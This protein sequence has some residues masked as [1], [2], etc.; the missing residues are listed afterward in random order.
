MTRPPPFRASL[1]P[2]PSTPCPDIATFDVE[3]D[4]VDAAAFALRYRLTGAIDRIRLPDPAEPVR[5]DGLWRHTCL[6][7]FVGAP[8]GTGYVEYNFA[9]SGAWAAYA[10]DG[11]REGMRPHE[12]MPPAIV[13]T[14]SV[15]TLVVAVSGALPFQLSTDRRLAL[16]IT[17]VIESRDGSL[18]YWALA[19]PA[20]RPDFH[21]R[22][23]HVLRLGRSGITHPSETS[24]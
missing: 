20:D 24:A 3:V 23:G 15:T 13:A 22:D 12:T 7:L 6:E 14:P 9:P 5:T 19:H 17:A 10:F 1:R 18:S 16:G 8:D 11:C 2:H 4:I 21:H